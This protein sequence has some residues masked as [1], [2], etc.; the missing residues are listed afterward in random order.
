MAEYYG[1]Y[2]RKSDGKSN[3]SICVRFFDGLMI[4]L[5]VITVVAV[6]FTYIAPYVNPASSWIFSIFG[7]VAPA[8]YF[9][10]LLLTLYWVIRWRWIPA[11]VLLVLLFVGLFKVSLFYKPE[12]KRIY[13]E[14]A[15]N[16]RDMMKFMTYNV[17]N[18]FGQ[19]GQSS[20]DDVLRLVANENPDIL[21]MQEFNPTLFESSK[22]YKSFMESYLYRAGGTKTDMETAPLAIYSKYP[23]LHWGH[24]REGIPAN[25]FR[26]SIWADVRVADDTVRVFNNHLHSTAI[27]ASDDEFITKHQYI[28]DTARDLKIRSIVKRFRDNSI[29]RAEEVDS[30]AQFIQSTH[31]ARIVCG[32]FNDTPMSYVYRAMAEGLNDAFRECGVGYSH[33]FRGFFNTLRIDFVLSSDDFESLS[34]EVQDVDYS[35]HHPVIVRLKYTPRH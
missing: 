12:F 27:N 13:V 8:T 5:S 28:S 14:P 10:L 19:D 26:E 2:D 32:D 6:L 4:L 7:L 24:S 9:A 35:D 29:L 25:G 11:S 22:G 16:E 18:F 17:R 34:Y 20:A 21:C 33:T 30:I 15:Y 3:F 31:Y 1:G 23:V